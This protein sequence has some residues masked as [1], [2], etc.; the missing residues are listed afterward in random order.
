MYCNVFNK[1]ENL[2]KKYQILKKEHQVIQ[3]FTVSVVI[4]MKNYLKRRNQLR[5]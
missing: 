2:K 1:I 5:Y 3:L 4:N